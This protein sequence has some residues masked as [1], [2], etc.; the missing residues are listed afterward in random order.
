MSKPKIRIKLA[1][2]FLLRCAKSQISFMH[3]SQ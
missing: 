3:F 1:Y 2:F